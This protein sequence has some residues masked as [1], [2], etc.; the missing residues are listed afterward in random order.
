MKSSPL[1]KSVVTPLKQMPTGGAA[2]L[3][4]SRVSSKVEP[5]KPKPKLRIEQ[6]LLEG[7][8]LYMQG[9]ILS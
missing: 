5:V 2:A 3:P 7:N 6:G 1:Q 8:L 9:G 4:A